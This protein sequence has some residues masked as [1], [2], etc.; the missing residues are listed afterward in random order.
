MPSL[1]GRLFKFLLQN[2]HLL[3]FQWRKKIIDWSQYE[4]ILNFRKEV[5]AGAERFG[6]VPKN[7]V[8]SPVNIDGLYAEWLIP[9]GVAKD[10][11]MLYFHGGGYV[12]GSCK[13]HRSITSKFVTGSQTGALLFDYRLAPEHPYP[14]GLEDA[15]KAY[16]WLLDGGI[17]PSSIVFVGDSGGGGLLL[18]TLLALRDQDTPLPAA[19]VACSP[20][21]DLKCAGESHRTKAKLCLSPEGMALAIARHYAG[22]KGYEIPYASPLYAELHGLPPLLIYVGEDEILRDDSTQFAAKAKAEGVDV[23]LRVGEG[24]F[25]CYPATAPLF[26]EATEAMKEIC[27][28]IRRMLK[29]E[30][31][32]KD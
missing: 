18:G 4:A 12:C 15:L 2:R 17:E 31:N 3:Q 16:R 5:E 1:R 28:F 27:T 11:I 10:K 6:K 29:I 13:S 23:T 32:L 30:S 25:H 20:V 26:P 7:I 24:M 22:D 9:E 8:I 14:A 19:A 21:T